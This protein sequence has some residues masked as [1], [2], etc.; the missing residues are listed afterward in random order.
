MLQSMPRK[1]K[2][3]TSSKNGFNKSEFIRSYPD[4]K[5]ADIIQKA[6]EAGQDVSAALV[7]AIRSADKHKTGGAMKGPKGKTSGAPGLSGFDSA[8]RAIVR[9]ELKNILSR[10]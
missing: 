7:Y 10:L 6:Q 4:L 8:I 9:E 1:S 5:P 2:S 3:K